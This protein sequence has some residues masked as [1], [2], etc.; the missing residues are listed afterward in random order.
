MQDAM[1][2]MML[3]VRRGLRA[4]VREPLV[5]F[6]LGGL[7]IFLI[8]AIRGEPADPASR[9]IVVDAARAEQLAARWQ[10]TWQRPPTRAEVDALIRD[11]IKEEIYYREAKRLG[12]DEND[13]GIRRRLRAKMEYLASAELENVRPSDAVLSEW[14]AR[15]PGRYTGDARYSFDQIYLGAAAA[16]TVRAALSRGAAW[17]EQR[18]RISLPPSLDDAPRAEVARIFGAPFADQLA[19]RIAR[20][21]TG[22]WTGPVPSGFG[23]HLVRLR[24][25]TDAAPP[26]LDKIRAD[27]ENDWRAAT[28]EAREARAYQLL[29]DTYT[30][31]IR[32]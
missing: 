19:T 11:D 26:Q 7:A 25:V 15:R 30:I 13:A 24:R 32:P 27:A 8:F 20:Q 29:L 5:H 14:V 6:L 4:A 1:M 31:V 22:Q 23:A 10:Q 28:L 18:A 12:L 16:D 17:Q 3:P 2:K 9:T 21:P